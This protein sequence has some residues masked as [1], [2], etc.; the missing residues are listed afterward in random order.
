MYAHTIELVFSLF[1]C[2]IIAKCSN[3]HKICK[4]NKLVYQRT[5]I[6]F[7]SLISRISLYIISLDAKKDNNND[8]IS[9]RII[10]DF[11][12]FTNSKRMSLKK[13]IW[14]FSRPMLQFKATLSKL[15]LKLP[16]IHRVFHHH[17]LHHPNN[18]LFPYL[19][20]HTTR[21]PSLYNPFP[22]NKLKLEECSRSGKKHRRKTV[23]IARRRRRKERQETRWARDGS[24]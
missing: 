18:H 13:K 11:I 19:L 1:L 2:F 9:K 15:N 14:T 7:I 23:A 16:L 5:I 6:Y 4:R 20:S 8:H 21:Y 10:T 24:A 22:L 12:N 3:S 17:H